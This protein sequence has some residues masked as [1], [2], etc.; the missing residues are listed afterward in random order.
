MSL[1]LKTDFAYEFNLAGIMVWSIDTDD[2]KGSC[3]GKK[4][5]LLR[6]INNQVSVL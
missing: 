5:P 4:F 2:F 3:N 6:A 1:R